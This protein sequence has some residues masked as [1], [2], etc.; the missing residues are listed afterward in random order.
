MRIERIGPRIAAG[1][2]VAGGA[3]FAV[4]ALRAGSFDPLAIRD[5]IAGSS[6]APVLFL[7]LQV[8][9]SLLFVPRT[10]LGIAAG[11]L[12]GFAGGVVWAISGAMLG[13]AA[14]FAL[15]R[16]MGAGEF[17]LDSMP[18]LGPLVKRA[19]RGGWRS[20]AI[21]R[22]IPGIPHSLSNTA[23]ALTR[24]G[25][26]DYLVGSFLGMLPMTLIQVDIGAAGG[27]VLQGQGGWIV[28]S[29]LLAVALAASF[30]VKRVIGRRVGGG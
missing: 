15:W 28:G 3:I 6:W 24:V 26:S 14:G 7:G 25:W 30:L 16:W 18:R 29:L 4:G 22:L 11:L 13:A 8:L 1:L 27:H 5:F 2:L 17:D 21:V 23:L 20:V 12:F 19:E 10:P 9:A